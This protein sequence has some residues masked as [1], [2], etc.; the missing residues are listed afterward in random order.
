LMPLTPL[1]RATR[2]LMFG[3]ALLFLL[4]LGYGYA[5]P[6]ES[7]TA[8]GL[9]REFAFSRKNYFSEKMAATDKAADQKYEKVA[10]VS[11]YSGAFSA[12]EKALR[13]LVPRHRALIQF[14]QSSGLAGAR[15]LDVAIGV[16]PS[17]FD[18]MVE[19]ARRIGR[20]QA[21]RVDKADKTNEYRGLN[22]KRLSLEKTRDS[23][24]RLKTAGGGRI[25]ELMHL[26]NRLLEIESELQTLGVQLGDYDTE[27]EFCT[28]KVTLD[29]RPGMGTG[30]PLL[31]RVKVALEW[32]IKY[33]AL[34][35]FIAALGT[36]TLWVL[37]QI[38]EK[39]RN[40]TPVNPPN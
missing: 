12:D 38:I 33:Y 19:A 35:V 1:G 6:G 10:S 28:V 11:T 8:S 16:P 31:T 21:I 24:T 14:E 7:A 34:L 3:F 17:E 27:N 30:I 23:L 32:T 37:L 26:E 9:L 36:G 15:H 39:L 4:R 2:W 22:A 13:A 29:E 20:L 25:E 40:V 5:H 18:A